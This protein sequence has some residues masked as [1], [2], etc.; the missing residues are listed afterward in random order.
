MPAGNYAYDC[1][2]GRP[3]EERTFEEAVLTAKESEGD[4]PLDP[5]SLN[6]LLITR[7]L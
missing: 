1:E 7:V 3:A 6:P 2:K 4:I 5:A